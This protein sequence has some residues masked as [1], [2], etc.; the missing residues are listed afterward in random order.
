MNRVV[1]FIFL[2]LV[3]FY[4][5]TQPK[6]AAHLVQNIGGT[7]RDAAESVTVFFSELA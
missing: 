5:I 4:I 7:L 2:A 1:G 6:D 3:V